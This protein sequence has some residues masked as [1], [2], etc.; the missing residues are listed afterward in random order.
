MMLETGSQKTDTTLQTFGTIHYAAHNHFNHKRNIERRTRFK[1]SEM[2]LFLNGACLSPP[3][4][5][6]LTLLEIGSH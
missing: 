2:L 6:C 3:D 1:D 4:R 5:T